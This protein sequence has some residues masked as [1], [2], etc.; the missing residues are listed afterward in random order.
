VKFPLAAFWHP[1]VDLPDERAGSGV[2]WNSALQNVWPL[3]YV[4]IWGDPFIARLPWRSATQAGR[5][6]SL[7]GV[8]P[9]LLV[10]SGLFHSTI[11]FLLTRF[12]SIDGPLVV[13]ALAGFAAFAMFTWINPA[14][15]AVKGGYLLPLAVPSA[16][17]FGQA[18]ARLREPVR[19]AVLLVC[20]VSAAASLVLFTDRLMFSA[21]PLSASQIR[22]WHHVDEEVPVAHIGSSMNRLMR[23]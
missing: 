6:L 4:S 7:L 22:F 19:K 15:V 12:R 23:P 5:V 17:F 3:A 9:T 18:A 14:L 2:K 20:A 10:L 21:K 1:T 13:M 16:A 11:Q 8:L